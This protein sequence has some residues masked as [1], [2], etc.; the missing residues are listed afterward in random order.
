MAVYPWA[1]SCVHEDYIAGPGAREPYPSHCFLFLIPSAQPQLR[2][3]EENFP[4]RGPLLAGTQ[5]SK[6]N[7]CSLLWQRPFSGG[8]IDPNAS[9]L[10]KL[11]VHRAAR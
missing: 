6:D 8:G 7:L 11:Q 4:R 10:Y 5:V 3:I 1:L 9:L 2:N